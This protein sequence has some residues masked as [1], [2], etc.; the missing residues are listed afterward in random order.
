MADENGFAVLFCERFLGGF[1]VRGERGERIFD[2]RDVIALLREDIGDRLP[3]RLIDESAMHEHDIA[4]RAL[5]RLSRLRGSGECCGH[6][7]CGG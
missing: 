6:E 7:D 2:E 1:D 4:N 5:G 3:A